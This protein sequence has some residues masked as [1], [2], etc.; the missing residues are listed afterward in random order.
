MYCSF[1]FIVA[2]LILPVDFRSRRSLFSGRFMSILTASEPVIQPASFITK[3][4]DEL[5]QNPPIS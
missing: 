2:L 3:E 4:K 1:S 5:P